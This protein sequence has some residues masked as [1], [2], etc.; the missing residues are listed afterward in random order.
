M[1]DHFSK[2]SSRASSQVTESFSEHSSPSTKNDF[3]CTFCKKSL[4]SR[5]NLREHEYIHTGHRPYQCTF[6][7]CSARFRQG[8]QLSL[9]KKKHLKAESKTHAGE[10]RIN[11][12]ILPPITLRKVASTIPNVFTIIRS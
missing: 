4:S 6:T 1:V 5:Q 3:I 2:S 8:S 10:E 11:G 12:L 9:H 7:G